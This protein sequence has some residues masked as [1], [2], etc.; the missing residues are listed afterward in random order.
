[1]QWPDGLEDFMKLGSQ[2]G[3]ALVL[4][5]L[6]IMLLTTMS[7]AMYLYSTKQSL[8]ADSEYT[9]VAATYIADA[10][11]EHGKA[12]LARKDILLNTYGQNPADNRVER[13]DYPVILPMSHE[14]GQIETNALGE[15]I[16]D[17]KQGVG[18]YS[19]R[20]DA[21]FSEI[22]D[23][24]VE[25]LRTTGF[26]TLKFGDMTKINRLLPG[27]QLKLQ[28]RQG[29]EV[30]NAY[31]FSYLN[32]R[33]MLGQDSG[34]PRYEL[35]LSNIINPFIGDPITLELNRSDIED[36]RFELN[37]SNIRDAFGNKLVLFPNDVNAG[38]LTGNRQLF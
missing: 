9:T 16:T 38:T 3:S 35:D 17:G 22:I 19:L 24:N 31:E 37:P 15:R 20:I 34:I 4:T 13:D 30:V 14:L 36:D 7:T 28:I 32:P 1:M 25:L 33:I 21:A 6:F 18:S 29:I 26:D 11:I 27:K 8:F 5:L 2:N 23:F 12:L 10:G